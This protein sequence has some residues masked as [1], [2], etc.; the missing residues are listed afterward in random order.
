[1]FQNEASLIA[2]HFLMFLTSWVS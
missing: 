2:L 1:L